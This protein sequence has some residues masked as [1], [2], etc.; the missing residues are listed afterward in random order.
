MKVKEKELTKHKYQHP[1]YASHKGKMAEWQS[2][3]TRLSQTS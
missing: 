1:P 2:F 3:L